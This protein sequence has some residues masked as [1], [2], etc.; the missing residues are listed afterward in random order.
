MRAVVFSVAALGFIAQFAIAADVP[1]VPAV[2][3]FHEVDE[4]VYRGGQP[5]P[6]G[7]KELSKFGIKT[8]IDLTGGAE[9]SR[10]EKEAV[11]AL[12]M[13]YVHVPMHGLQA[14][15]DESMWRVLGYLSPSAS[16]T[17]PV[18]IHCKRGKDRT[19]T[20]VAC[21]RI[22]HDHWD[23]LKALQEAKMNGMSKMERAMQQYILH[24]QVKSGPPDI[25]KS[26]AR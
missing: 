25:T 2:H 17:W 16:A 12:G 1:P 26:I 9:H 18:F 10:E 21:Y 23:N 6:E 19:G 8:V 7:L 22:T 11:Q 24:F 15:T 13:Q 4:R 14:P 3:N 5:T 20:V